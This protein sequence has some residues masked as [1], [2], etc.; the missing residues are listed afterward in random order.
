MSDHIGKHIRNILFSSFLFNMAFK[1]NAQ[2]EEGLL[3]I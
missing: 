1:L 3:L 2:E